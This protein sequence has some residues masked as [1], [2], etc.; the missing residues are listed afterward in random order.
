MPENI[1]CMKIIAPTYEE[2][3]YNILLP[4]VVTF[5]PVNCIKAGYSVQYFI[6][7]IYINFSSLVQNIQIRVCTFYSRYSRIM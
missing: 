4:F 2:M 1:V 6:I 5:Q 3:P 7:I